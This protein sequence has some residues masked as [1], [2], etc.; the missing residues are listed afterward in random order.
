V[1]RSLLSA[2][3][4]VG[5]VSALA[6][7]GTAAAAE[8]VTTT[9]ERDGVTLTYQRST[10]DSAYPLPVSSTPDRASTRFD[11]DGDGVDELITAAGTFKLPGDTGD[12]SVVLIRHSRGGVVERVLKHNAG[13]FGAHLAVAD[14]DNDGFGDLIASDGG[15]LWVF[16]GGAD[17]LVTD[18]TVRLTAARAG[19][20]GAI[21]GP[22]AVGDLNADGY[23]D[24]AVGLPNATAGKAERAGAA[25]VLFGGPQG[26]TGAGSVQVTQETAGVPGT[27][28]AGDLFGSALAVGDVTGDA[29][30]DLVVGARGD[31]SDD[32][33]SVTVLPGT[34]KGPTGTGSTAVT[35]ESLDNVAMH[36]RSFG[37]ELAVAEVTG[38]GRADVVA[39]APQTTVAG[40]QI[41][42]VVVVLPGAAGGINAATA[43]SWGPNSRGVAGD[44]TSGD[45]FG[46][47][48]AVGDLT[49]DARPDVLTAALWAPVGGTEDAGTVTMLPNGPA[50]LTGAGSRQITGGHRAFGTDVQIVEITGDGPREALVAANL[51]TLFLYRAQG[52]SLTP[53]QTLTPAVFGAADLPIMFLT[54]ALPRGVPVPVPT[55]G[56]ATPPPTPGPAKAPRSRFD[57]D[58]DGR[59]E[60]VVNTGDG[61]VIRYTATGRAD[62]LDGRWQYVGERMSF[63]AGDFNGDGYAD[64]AVGDP[65]ANRD[66][67]TLDAPGAV[68]VCDGGPERIEYQDCRYISQDTAGVPGAGET[69]D[70]FGT[71]V[72]AGDLNGDGRADLAVGAPGEA[73]GKVDDAGGVTVLY[74]SPTGI[75]TTGA[76]WIDQGLTWVPGKVEDSDRLGERLAA[77]DV[78]G[79]GRADLVL[80]APGENALGSVT[81]VKGAA[82]GLS[83]TGARTIVY[84]QLTSNTGS[85]AA[86]GSTLAVAD[87]NRDGRAEVVAGAPEAAAGTAPSAGVV[88]ALTGSAAGI[89]KAAFRIVHQNSTGVSG[90]AESG[91]Q[92]GASLATGD[93]G[94]D[95]YVDVLV[96]SPDEAIGSRTSAG[97]VTVLRGG[98]G[99]LTGTGGASWTQDS[100]GVPGGTEKF[101]WFGSS[102]S[103]LNLDGTGALDVLVGASGEDID[104]ENDAGSVT[105]FTGG[106]AG[107][108]PTTAWSA[109]NLPADLGGFH[110][111]HSLGRAMLAG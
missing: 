99:G 4:V 75:A 76:T 60:T 59:D 91:D 64:L 28:E 15:A 12:S 79:D 48:I 39:G 3:V 56:P 69:G 66:R 29:T 8:P 108:T 27:A 77:G 50:G 52:G 10:V 106:A 38:D 35:S 18:R 104:G 23:A 1:R 86:F 25:A 93:V 78:T 54:V 21:G 90:A 92:F 85:G 80:G 88:V 101:D 45:D 74:G 102:V 6:P 53:V 2:A 41:A 34:G 30:L 17:G 72:A 46:G 111:D 83:T 82:G 81:L 5:C 61:A 19:L 57:L 107:L 42:G 84:S 96:G 97:S 22:P 9:I 13:T 67:P 105:Q 63:A 73:I 71:T 24:V 55:A 33:G 37:E 70:T 40:R 109:L 31:G 110:N 87:L 94:G 7:V 98:R 62:K 43:R 44:A 32:E 65:D 68:W 58:G 51:S 89:D 16:P 14:V 20:T 100:S 11:L 36:T 26:L 103:V 95:G 49:G 47:K